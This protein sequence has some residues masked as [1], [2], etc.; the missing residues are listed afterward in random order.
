M[1]T[2]HIFTISLLALASLCGVVGLIVHLVKSDST[3]DLH[4][5]TTDLV[6]DSTTD[7]PSTTPSPS[8]VSPDTCPGG[9][10]TEWMS[11]HCNENTCSVKEDRVCV[12]NSKPT[13]QEDREVPC[14]YGRCKGNFKL[15]SLGD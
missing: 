11:G 13:K 1:K 5:T 14:Y 9:Q 6:T 4:L 7:S 15:F 3:T 10:W 12:V 8:T 2:W